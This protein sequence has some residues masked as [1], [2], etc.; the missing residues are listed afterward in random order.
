MHAVTHIC[1]WTWRSPRRSMQA[2]TEARCSA[3]SP[4][5]RAFALAPP[6]EFHTFIKWPVA[7]LCQGAQV[8]SP[9]KHTLRGFEDV[10]FFVAS[11]LCSWMCWCFF[12]ILFFFYS[13]HFPLPFLHHCG[14]S[15]LCFPP[16]ACG[17]KNIIIWQPIRLCPYSSSDHPEVLGE[18]GYFQWQHLQA[19]NVF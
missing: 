14:A 13:M 3:P 19:A 9:D 2:A 18:T 6:K 10:F 5:P 16:L 11:D 7:F 1:M 4:P 12:F 8:E 15:C 17:R